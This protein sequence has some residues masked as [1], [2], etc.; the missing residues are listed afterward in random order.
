MDKTT[1]QASRRALLCG[2]PAVAAAGL[3]VGTVPNIVAIATAKAAEP[4][5]VT[6]ADPDPLVGRAKEYLAAATEL[7]K[8]ERVSKRLQ[9]EHR[10]KYPM[11][12]AL[13]VRPEDDELGIPNR[14]KMVFMAWDEPIPPDHWCL[15]HYNDA[16][17]IDRL[18]KPQ[19]ERLID[20]EF[21]PGTAPY[22]RFN[23][24]VGLESFE[25]SPAARARADEIIAAYDGWKPKYD[26]DPKGMA[27]LDRQHDRLLSKR[28]PK[29]PSFVPRRRLP[30]C[31]GT[32]MPGPT[33]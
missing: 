21:R 19:W 3:A 22:N 7:Q 31:R 9:E 25:P 16:W 32:S 5:P 23:G 2:I 14:M 8:I 33:P 11:P 12:D 28:L 29:P 27:K 1:P 26:R 15:K 18:R 13:L 6:A 30:F 24:G 4:E 17:C 20:V 10:A